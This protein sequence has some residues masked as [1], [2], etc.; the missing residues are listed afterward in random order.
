MRVTW[1]AAHPSAWH[2][3]R[4]DGAEP[5]RRGEE[6]KIHHPTVGPSVCGHVAPASHGILIHH[7]VSGTLG[8]G[9]QAAAPLPGCMGLEP[10]GS[11]QLSRVQ[12]KLRPGGRQQKLKME[13]L[14]ADRPAFE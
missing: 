10:S 1:Q 5:L 3:A 13:T 9:E 14:E 11:L 2:C 4:P 6:G 12:G 8:G 7:A